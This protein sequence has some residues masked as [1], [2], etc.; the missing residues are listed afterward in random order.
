MTSESSLLMCAVESIVPLAKQAEACANL[1]AVS[2]IYKEQ[3]NVGP[4]MGR[5]TLRGGEER[6]CMWRGVAAPRS[7]GP[8]ME[9]V[10]AGHE[11]F[12]LSSVDV[13]GNRLSAIIKPPVKSSVAKS[14]LSP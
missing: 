14:S 10:P 11:P 8:G 1:Q 2:G 5:V 3:R 12:C 9:E 7:W 4:E 13:L 6:R